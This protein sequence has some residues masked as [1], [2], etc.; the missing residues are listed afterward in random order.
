[1][2]LYRNAQDGS[3]NRWEP[4]WMRFC[5][6]CY[7]LA[8]CQLPIVVCVVAHSVQPVLGIHRFEAT[9]QNRGSEG[10]FLSFSKGISERFSL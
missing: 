2:D 1:M 8:P 3:G 7:T 6:G 10:C 5:L 9:G 4:G